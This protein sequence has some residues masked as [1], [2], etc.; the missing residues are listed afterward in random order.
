M[1]VPLDIFTAHRSSRFIMARPS[2]SEH[3]EYY[4]KYV[5]LVPEDDITQALAT[6]LADAQRLFLRVTE[7]ESCKR[8]PPYT[9][10]IKQV[11]GHLS[12]C[13][14]IFGHRALRFARADATPLP[15]FDENAYAQIAGSDLRAWSSLVQEFEAIRRSHLA[16]FGTMIEEAW[17]RRGIANGQEVSVRALAYI[18]VG[19]QRHHLCIVSS[20]LGL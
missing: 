9:W 6:S 18:I 20:R 12:D 1:M 2:R 11:L 3:A 14:R 13:E 17:Q 4:V 16:L 8:H 10:S 5:D 7:E 15:G 19:H